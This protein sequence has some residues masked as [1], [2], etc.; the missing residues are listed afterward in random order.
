MI[1][2]GKHTKMDWAVKNLEIALSIIGL[3]LLGFIAYLFS[4]GDGDVWFVVAIASII[5]GLIN[6]VIL[7]YLRGRQHTLRTE[8]IEEIREMLKDTITNNLS[9]ISLNAQ[10]SRSME[11]NRKTTILDTITKIDGLLDT[12]SDKSLTSWKRHYKE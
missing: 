10:L 6:A 9:V 1:D 2:N 3:L 8:T 12:L 11:D 7:W 5:I 4:D